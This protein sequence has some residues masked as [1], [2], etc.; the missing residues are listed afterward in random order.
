MPLA[1]PLEPKNQTHQV[2]VHTQNND[3]Y[4]YQESRC[5]HVFLIRVYNLI[6]NVP[7][8]RKER[9]C[10]YIEQEL[11]TYT[12]TRSLKNRPISAGRPC[13]C[14]LHIYPPVN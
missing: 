3:Q 9:S 11:T 2:P 14:S 13:Q 7:F 12:R 4:K 10:M 6:Y 5:Q 8:D 1:V